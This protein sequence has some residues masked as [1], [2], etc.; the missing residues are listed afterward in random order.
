MTSKPNTIKV[1]EQYNELKELI[2]KYDFMGYQIVGDVDVDSPL[3]WDDIEKNAFTVKDY[4]KIKKNGDYVV[5][6]EPQSYNTINLYN[7]SIL[8]EYFELD[9]LIE[10]KQIKDNPIFK[11]IYMKVNSIII[12]K[13]KKYMKKKDETEEKLMKKLLKT[14]NTQNT[15]NTQTTKPKKPKKST[16]PVRNPDT[17]KCKI[18]TNESKKSNSK[19]SNSK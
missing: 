5:L 8:N 4:K 1:K 12:N 7:A 9:E 18:N 10:N 15:Q 11:N 3:S 16:E 13:L 14:Q 2:D 19:K 6:L 17:N